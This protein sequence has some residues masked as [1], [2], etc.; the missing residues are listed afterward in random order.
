MIFDLVK[1]NMNVLCLILLC[2]CLDIYKYI[3][4]K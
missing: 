3:L 2:I 4:I 1:S